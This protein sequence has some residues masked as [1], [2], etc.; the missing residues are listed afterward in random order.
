VRAILTYHSIDPSGSPIS[1]DEAAFRAHVGWLAAGGVRVV[2][3]ERITD[4]GAP[5]EAVALTFDDA[6]ANFADVAW[7]LLRQ[8]ALPVTL[9]VVSGHAGGTNAWGGRSVPNIPVLPLM[10]WDAIGRVAGEGV[11]I[12]AHTRT[13]PDLR[14][15][16]PGALDAELSGS[17]DD[18]ALRTGTRPT[19]FAYPYG[20]VDAN[21]SAAAARTFRLAVTTQL[22][23]L[24]TDDQPHRLPRLDAFYLREPG[25]L[26]AWG[27]PAFRRRLE[28][29]ATLRRVRGALTGRPA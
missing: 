2:P 21:V 26:E 11:T 3:L 24:A 10:H 28:L 1:I 19:T 7:P 16:A 27:T 12:G 23:P 17:A 25:Q 22:R 20:G 15:A 13:H 29:R 4:P 14:K 5:D 8:H 6:F 18:I 9:F